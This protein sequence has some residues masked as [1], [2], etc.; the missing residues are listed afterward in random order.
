MIMLGAS[1]I[2]VPGEGI[3]AEGLPD[4][5]G[6]APAGITPDFNETV[7]TIEIDR[8]AHTGRRAYRPATEF[9]YEGE[10]VRF[11]LV[12]DKNEMV[13]DIGQLES[14][15]GLRVE[16]MGNVF[17]VGGV[18]KDQLLKFKVLTGKAKKRRTLFFTMRF[19]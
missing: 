8:I 2:G 17:E 4:V 19:V 5:V 3:E 18:E 15:D 14:L 7:Q 6:I 9:C 16:Q 1:F 12:N 10:T 11:S 13:K